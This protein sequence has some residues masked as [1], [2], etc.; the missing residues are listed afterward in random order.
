MVN[1]VPVEGDPFAQASLTPAPG[2][3]HL[4]PVDH[5]PFGAEQKPI[6]AGESLAFG[7]SRPFAGAAQLV[8]HMAP[9][10]TTQA[11]LALAQEGRPI[12]SEPMQ[13]E[14]NFDIT[15]HIDEGIASRE[16]DFKK[17]HGSEGLATLGQIGATL[18]LAALPGGLA[19]QGAAAGALQPVTGGDYW[20]TKATD[21]TA[22]AALSTVFGNLLPPGVR[23]I[24]KGIGTATTSALGV[25][26]GAGREPIREAF[27]AAKAGGE[28][29]QAFLD[30]LRDKVPVDEVVTMGR[31]ALNKMRQARNSLYRSGMVDIGSD[32]ARL[33]FAPV[34]AALERAK[35]I[36]EYEG[37]TVNKQA[38]DRLK[39]AEAA[40]TEWKDGDPS[41]FH[42][43]EGFD[44]LKQRLG[45]IWESV[46]PHTRA[47]AIVGD[48]YRAVRDSIAQQA[49][50]YAKIM[51][52][53]SDSSTTIHEI[54]RALSLNKKASVDAA[55]RKLQSV[56]RNN[57]QTN[58]GNRLAMV[59]T[60]NELADGKLSPAIA[61]HALND[62]VPRGL[63]R[64]GLGFGPMGAALGHPAALAA[65]P[66]EL[67][68]LVGEG[69]AGLGWLARQLGL[70][71][72]DAVSNALSTGVRR[73]VPGAV[74]AANVGGN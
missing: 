23:F 39:E 68:R 19:V 49:P 69:A 33:D 46:E 42:T 50:T 3:T 14:P 61:G 43:A 22:D 21:I 51:K 31:N 54:E 47:S 26:T 8:A 7:A 59:D 57:V 11:G 41:K 25:L 24:S 13:A 32:S 73:V 55:L 56:M 35:G 15:K 16:A 4:V 17:R 37:V 40:V 64:L 36:A 12:G 18:P 2:G 65:L 48:A 44:K 20:K 45:E 63:S 66:L 60:L 62:M 38:A 52:E 30:A 67:P 53:Y 71:G 29:A 74:G 34:D 27:R 9:Q 58:Y 5:D 70:H 28:H 72:D 1:L 6:G 10:A